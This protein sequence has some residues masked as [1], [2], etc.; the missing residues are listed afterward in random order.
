MHLGIHNTMQGQQKQQFSAASHASYSSMSKEV[1]PSVIFFS[2]VERGHQGDLL[3]AG[4]M[5]QINYKSKQTMSFTHSRVVTYNLWFLEC[6]LHSLEHSDTSLR[7]VAG[8][9]HK[10]LG[11][12]T[13]TDASIMRL[14]TIELHQVYN[15]ANWRMHTVWFWWQC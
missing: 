13:L 3:R 2:Q 12:V 8:I 9:D 10:T 11:K 15:T 4:A 7:V 14:V 1:R 5:R 6:F